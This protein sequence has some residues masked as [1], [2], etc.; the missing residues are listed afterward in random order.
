MMMRADEN[1]ASTKWCTKS[2]L[3]ACAWADNW[4][5]CVAACGSEEEPT[6]PGYATVSTKAAADQSVALNAVDKKIWTVTLKAGENDT[7]VT[8][9]EITKSWL[10]RAADIDKIQLMKDGEYVTRWWDLNSNSIAKLRF[11]PNLVIKAN[12]SETF[13][14]VVSMNNAIPWWQH[15]FAVTSVTVANWTFGWTP[16]N[17]G[18]L[19][20]TNYTVPSATVTLSNATLKAWDSNKQIT[21]INIASPVNA[22]L[23]SITL[24]ATPTINEDVDNMLSNVKAYVDDKEV[25]T[26]SVNEESIVI[27]N[28]STKIE[29]N[30]DIDVVLKWTDIFVWD[31]TTIKLE[32]DT[33]HVVVFEDNT[34][35]R[36]NSSYD[37]KTLNIQWVDLKINNNV[38]TAQTEAV[39]TKNVKFLDMT[40]TSSN[41][42]DIA[43]FYVVLPRTWWNFDWQFKDDEI[44]LYVDGIDYTIKSGN[45]S[46][47]WLVEYNSLK[48]Y[49]F[50]VSNNHSVKVELKWTP[51][52]NMNS[53]SVTFGITKAQN[54]DEKNNTFPVS[55][56]KKVSHK[57]TIKWGNLTVSKATTPSANTI[58]MWAEQEVLFFKVKS[59]SENV[60]LTWLNISIEWKDALNLLTWRNNT[61]ITNVAIYKEDETTPIAEFD[62]DWDAMDD[63]TK[64]TNTI[65]TWIL[66][67]DMSSLVIENGKTVNFVVKATFDNWEVADLWNTYKFTL[68]NVYWEWETSKASIAL[69]PNVEWLTYTVVTEKPDIE[70]VKNG[71]FINVTLKN[72]SAYDVLLNSWAAATATWVVSIDIESVAS[73]ND[74]YLLDLS[75]L[76]WAVLDGENGN[77]M[78]TFG[79]SAWTITVTFTK[80]L[81][82]SAWSEEE[83]TIKLISTN[84]ILDSYYNVSKKSIDFNYYDDTN[85]TTSKYVNV[86]Y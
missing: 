86:K 71:K 24:T 57:T 26:V 28:L 5:E 73:A 25:W 3:V 69:T 39:N 44:T 8:A 51:A 78:W 61:P 54:I 79:Y 70:L 82:I 27:S 20:T 34:N 19:T 13:D 84:Q 52:T 47:T 38:T 29:K 83:F 1:A 9:I 68:S 72:N 12:S 59:P 15:N 85:D 58:E 42:M 81:S 33:W 45:I 76:S 63:W 4:N 46:S 50:T 41:E 80:D 36:M 74:N 32:A 75:S 43:A 53:V 49:G 66:L 31:S 14:V 77:E 6:L 56:M 35:E 16:A 23:N 40:V 22:T 2:E 60:K 17:L 67:D 30:D 11:R 10:G 21:T 48:D 37:T 18:S 65:S 7:T 64:A 62:F 55:N